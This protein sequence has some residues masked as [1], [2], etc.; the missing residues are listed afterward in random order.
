[1]NETISAGGNATSIHTAQNLIAAGD[2]AAAA[3]QNA[4]AI[5]YYKDAWKAAQLAVGRHCDG[6][7]DADDR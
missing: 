4:I 6:G 5:Y 7:N 1:L 3:G 2:Q